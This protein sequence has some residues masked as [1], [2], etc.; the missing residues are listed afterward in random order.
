MDL[1]RIEIFCKI[2]DLKS[3]TRAAEEVRLA[4]PT[5][6]DHMRQLEEELNEK[7]LER[8]GRIVQLTPA[9]KTFLPFA[10][11]MLLLRDEAR[12]ALARFR[13]DLSGKLLIG[14]STIPGAY[15]L[16]GQLQKFKA[17]HSG[18]ELSLKIAST[19]QTLSD[20]LDGKLELALTGASGKQGQLEFIPLAK[21]E[22]VLVVGPDHP[23]QAVASISPQQ[24]CSQPFILRE[25]GSGTRSS[26]AEALQQRGVR[27]SD[28]QV[29]AEMGNGEAVRQAV[30]AGIGAAIISRRAVAEEL[31][32][33]TLRSVPIQD[34]AIVRHIYLV[35]PLRRSLSPLAEA[36]SQHLLAQD[37]L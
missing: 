15:L 27:L 29:V 33:G 31:S 28:L 1:K 9:G 22:L 35:Q 11:R 21:D 37:F 25:E 8:S 16:P 14:A 7:L 23:W 32:A 6:S 12:Q 4:Q 26:M 36:F 34:L 5:V 20:L 30:K 3:F 2:V 13:G 18:I 10:R 17:A 24:L 19:Q